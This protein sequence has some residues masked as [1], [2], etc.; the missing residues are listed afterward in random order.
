M[1]SEPRVL[2]EKKK[3]K[4]KPENEICHNL[5]EKVFLN[6]IQSGEG[7]GSTP[8]GVVGVFVCVST[9]TIKFLVKIG[10]VTL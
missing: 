3:K 1:D 5:M 9:S 6:C 10:I 7:T 8:G 2:E 4:K